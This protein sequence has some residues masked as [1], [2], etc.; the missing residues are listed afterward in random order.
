MVQHRRERKSSPFDVRVRRRLRPWLEGL[1]RRELLA[2]A[3]PLAAALPQQVLSPATPPSSSAALDSPASSSTN[4]SVI[5]QDEPQVSAAPDPATL[6]PTGAQ[7]LA[8]MGTPFSGFVG[9]F[10]DSDTSAMPGD[11]TITINWGDNTPAT[12]G[13]VTGT[14]AAFNVQGSHTYATP[15]TG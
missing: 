10:T 14:P 1:E 13:T 5:P 2:S 15:R 3:D 8:A 9:S 4:T 7:V 6:T 12:A 11:F